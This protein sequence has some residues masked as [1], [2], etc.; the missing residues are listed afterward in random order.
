V[1]DLREGR[2]D[3]RLVYRKRLRGKLDSYDRMTPPQVRAARLADEHN[4]RLGRPLQYQGG[5][6]IRYVM[7]LNGPEPMEARRAA[8]DYDH[9]VEHQLRPIADAILPLVGGRF[10]T[11]VSQQS[12]LF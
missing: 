10:D 2:L 8:I 11:L 1:R 12:Q 7:T 4:A 5:G 6:W 9:Y 3:E